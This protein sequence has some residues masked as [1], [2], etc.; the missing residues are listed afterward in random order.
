DAQ[1]QA[2]RET[3]ASKTDQAP[4]SGSPLDELLWGTNRR[5]GMVE[6]MAKQA[7]RTVGSELGRKIL[8]GVL[9]GMLVNSRRKAEAKASTRIHS[10]SGQ[11][12]LR[13]RG[14]EYLP[15]SAARDDASS[16]DGSRRHSTCFNA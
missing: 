9:G 13:V 4:A 12:R 15:I 6:S 11:T 1:P 7:A 10:V 2:R 8:R 14:F 5:Q 3:S 16:R